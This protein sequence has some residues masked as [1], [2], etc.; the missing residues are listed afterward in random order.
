MTDRTAVLVI[1]V[2][3]AII[4]GLGGERAAANRAAL[5][6]AV[7]RMA[8]MLDRARAAG[9]PVLHVRHNEGPGE[10]LSTGT[11]G[12]EIRAEV[13]P[14]DGEPVID[15]H[16]CDSFYGT[17]LADRLRGLG[18]GHLVVM[19]CMTQFCID[20]ACR[21]AVSEGFGVTLAADAHATADLGPLT[22]EQTVAHHNFTLHGL[23]AG[24]RR[25]R[26]VPS[27]EIRF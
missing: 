26:V 21:R 8:E 5:D 10:N 27:A 9:V 4:D 23:S 6:Q 18:V 25:V 2:Q 7:A 19:G 3:N 22:A 15:K 14:H 16:H 20:T 12:W 13:A 24:D 11:P 17:G 1:D